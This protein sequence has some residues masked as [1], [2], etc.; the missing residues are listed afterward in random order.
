MKAI[1][2]HQYG[3]VE[4]LK[5]EEIA[6]PQPAQ[7]EAL[8]KVEAGGLNF[9]DVYQRVG[10]YKSQL[11]FTAGVEA[12][13]VVQALGPGVNEVKVGDRVVYAMYQGAFAQQACVPAWRLAVL[14]K[15]VGAHE[16]AAAFLQG[17]TA[18]YL[19]CTTYPIQAGDTVLIHAAA[20][21]LGL[22]LVQ[23]AKLRGAR[24]I[25]TVSS[26]IKA[27]AAK[28]AGADEVINYTEQDFEA[29][30]KR[31]TDGKGVPVVYDSVGKTTF[32]K[33]L[34]VLRRRGM[35]VLCGQSSGPVP[36]FDPQTLNAKGSLFLTRPTLGHYIA[37]RPELL[38]RA[39]D[40][41]GWMAAGKVK[42]KI[43]KTFPL[44]QTAQAYEY[45]ESRKAIGKVLVVP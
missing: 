1:R 44:S 7:G 30:V 38:Q 28:A 42:V 24:V 45:L 39:T 29:E 14:P 3:G 4:E 21:G 10:L 36:P 26:E 37:D 35:L 43:D 41:L 25:G 12:A 27:K 15:E 17:L 16:G 5:F 31:I 19:A 8:I 22:L 34:N 33:S 32:D 23:V 18:Q 13:G 6:V 9:I 2:V 40:L 20:G 11:P